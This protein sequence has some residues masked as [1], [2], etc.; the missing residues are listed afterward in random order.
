MN[1]HSLTG[2]FEVAA[3]EPEPF[4][5]KPY[6]L[7]QMVEVLLERLVVR[8]DLCL[9]VAELCGPVSDFAV[10][11]LQPRQTRVRLLDLFDLLLRLLHLPTETLLY[12][13]Q[14]SQFRF[15]SVHDLTLHL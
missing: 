12:V 8:I 6:F 1:G 9:R 5:A 10:Q 11:R 14:V 4:V 15:S 2:G 7:L 3:V 13:R